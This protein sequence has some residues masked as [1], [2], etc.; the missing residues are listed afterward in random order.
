MSVRFEAVWSEF[1]GSDVT[2]D[3][4]WSSAPVEAGFSVRWSVESGSETLVE[5]V[6][7]ERCVLR[8]ESR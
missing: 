3:R 5:K 2:E 7:G 4:R 6:K 8:T 1:T